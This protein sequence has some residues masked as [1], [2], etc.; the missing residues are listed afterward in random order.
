M[1]KGVVKY[2]I[3][4]PKA[5]EKAQLCTVRVA[6][7]TVVTIART[8]FNISTYDDAWCVETNVSRR[9][10]TTFNL[11]LG[12]GILQTGNTSRRRTRPWRQ[13]IWAH[14][15]MTGFR[16]PTFPRPLSRTHTLPAAQ[17]SNSTAIGMCLGGGNSNIFFWIF[18]TEKD[19][20]KDANPFFDVCAY[21]NGWD[22]F[23]PPR[24]LGTNLGST[25][26]LQPRSTAAFWCRAPRR[27]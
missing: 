25:L 20:K 26:P 2:T 8:C 15:V 6:G 13:R 18:T 1:V 22:F 27:S 10:D 9:Q 19:R 17:H 16:P 11:S 23:D 7:G 5:L 4:G 21:L 14:S 24:C 3:L 12:W